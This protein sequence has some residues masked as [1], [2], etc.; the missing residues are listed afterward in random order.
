MQSRSSAVNCIAAVT[1][2]ALLTMLSWVSVAPFG[3]PVVPEVNWMLTASPGFS[4]AEIASRRLVLVAAAHRRHVAEVEHAGRCVLAHADDD[5]ELG[6][7]AAAS[8][9]GSAEAISGASVAIIPR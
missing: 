7:L 4:V 6:S 8:P 9:P 2:L 1:K 5:F 3:A